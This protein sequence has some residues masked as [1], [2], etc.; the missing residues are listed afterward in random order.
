MKNIFKNLLEQVVKPDEETTQTPPVDAP[1]PADVPPPGTDPNTTPTEDPNMMGGGDMPP[2]SGMDPEMGGG[3]PGE[4]T[5][6]PLDIGRAYELKKIH[7]RLTSLESYLSTIADIE[8]IKLR[9]VVLEALELF[10]IIISN[11]N[12]YKDTID[13]VIV[14]YKGEIVEKGRKKDLF[15]SPDHDY[16]E[17]LLSSVPEMDP[18]WLDNLLI[19]REKISQL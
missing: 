9:N 17:L 14:M 12:S 10:Q 11:F 8:L 19:K 5:L 18:D 15:D 4:E 16:T 1:P 2:D 3:I 13:E 6:S 7:K